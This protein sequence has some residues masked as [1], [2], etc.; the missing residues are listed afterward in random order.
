MTPSTIATREVASMLGVTE[1]TVKR[2]AD[3]GVIP[4]VRTPG[5]HRKFL[6]KDVVS[7]AEQQGLTVAGVQPP[8]MNAE[9]TEQ[10]RLG[11]A[12]LDFKRIADV[13]R[14]EALQA[15]RQGLL[16]LLLY[17]T[18]NH[19]SLPVIAD[20]VI[21]PAFV[22]IGEL[23]VK[24]RLGVNQEHAA[25]QAMLEA[26]IRVAADLHRKPGKEMAVVCA[27]PEHELHEIGLRCLAYSLE[28]EGWNVHYIGANTPLDAMLRFLRTTHPQLVCVSV[29]IAR[30]KRESQEFIRKLNTATRAYGGILIVGGQ[31]AQEFAEKDLRCDYRAKGIQDTIEFIKDK[32]QLR[33]GPKKE[34]HHGNVQTT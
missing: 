25:T 31:G 21:R 30:P 23:W 16:S 3:E 8:P 1:T 22:E 28:G 7:F 34:T 32:F 20:E 9:Q 6:L 27:G 13:L 29:T 24:G 4:C 10:L 14:E 15:D 11:V 12:L 19:I 2:W 18:K 26:L 33:P 5:G 17:L